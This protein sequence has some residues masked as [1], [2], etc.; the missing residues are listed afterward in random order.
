[1]WGV[2]VNVGTHLVPNWR[3]MFGYDM[4]RIEFQ[5]EAEAKVHMDIHW[6]YHKSGCFRVTNTD[7]E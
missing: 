2:Q 1:M 6:G 4:N 7:E 5:T 3:W